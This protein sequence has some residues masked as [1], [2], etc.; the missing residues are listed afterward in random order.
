VANMS[1]PQTAEHEASGAGQHLL[2][3]TR[4]RDLNLLM[5]QR[6]VWK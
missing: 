5:G 4:D 6:P 3:T 1:A 2:D